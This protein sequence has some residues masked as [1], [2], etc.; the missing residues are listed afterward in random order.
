MDGNSK[1]FTALFNPL[2][3]VPCFHG[4]EG[5]NHFF[6]VDVK[7][8]TKSTPHFGHNDTDLML[9]ETYQSGQD[10]AQEVRYL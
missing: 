9:G 5:S 2:D 7:L 1:I 8:R 10:V 4:G 6:R 3:R